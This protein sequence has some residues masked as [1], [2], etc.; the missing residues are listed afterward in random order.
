MS[1]LIAYN[2]DDV[3]YMGTDTREIVNDDKRNDLCE[4]NY[5]IQRLENGLIVGA[6]AERLTRQ[7]IFAYPEV[8]TLDKKG[9]LT[10]KHVVKEII[11]K[12]IEV[13]EREELIVH[14][15]NKLPYMNA[16]VLLAHNGDLYE[17]CSNFSVYKYET[18]Q[19]LGTTSPYGQ[20]VLNNVKETDDV[21]EQ[22]IQ[23]LDVI[24]K[25]SQLVG[26]PYLLIDTKQKEY[27]LVGDN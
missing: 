13:L 7:S 17:I 21:N 23:A 2:K 11:P 24:A 12:L 4:C 6:T 25:N 15:E 16:G 1:I 5:K 19:A 22:I 27:K 20:F 14:A 18:F 9:E 8:F 3:I 10:R 26:K